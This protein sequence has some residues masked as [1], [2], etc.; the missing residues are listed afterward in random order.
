MFTSTQF[1][2]LHSLWDGKAKNVA[3]VCGNCGICCYKSD[4]GYFPGEGA[5][6]QERSGYQGTN[7]ALHDGRCTCYVLGVKAIICKLYPLII[8]TDA[9]GWELI[10]GKLNDAYTTKCNTLDFKGDQNL[11]KFL[12]YL[13]S[14][15]ENRMFWFMSF[16]LDYEAE[17]IQVAFKEHGKKVNSAEAEMRAIHNAM[18]L[19]FDDLALVYKYRPAKN[20]YKVINSDLVTSFGTAIRH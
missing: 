1:D 5:Y 14:D 13:F 12:D 9:R 11:V 17:A 3:N 2:F 16:N 6:L 15:V 20:S 4:K 8:K 19:D 18:F 10:E 7:Y